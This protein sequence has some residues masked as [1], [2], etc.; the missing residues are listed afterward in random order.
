MAQL[1]GWAMGVTAYGNRH[2]VRGIGGGDDGLGVPTEPLKAEM[3]RGL[4]YS[5]AERGIDEDEGRTRL[6]FRYRALLDRGGEAGREPQRRPGVGELGQYCTDRE[7]SL[8]T[9]GL[10]NA[11]LWERAIGCRRMQGCAHSSRT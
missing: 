11:E 5:V 2:S 8:V 3:R 1:G 9:V 4:V 6:T 7:T 10:D